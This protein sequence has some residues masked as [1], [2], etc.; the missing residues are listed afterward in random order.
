MKF[1]TFKV[2]IFLYMLTAG[3]PLQYNAI[4]ELVI[5]RD[6]P[7]S[8]YFAFLDSIIEKQNRNTD[9]ELNEHV[10]VRANSWIIDTLMQTDYYLQLKKGSFIDNQS[11]MIILRAGQK[12]LIPDSQMTANILNRFK[13]TWID[14]N[15]PE[16]KLRIYRDSLLLFT[17]PVR[18][19]ENASKYL[20]MND[21]ITDLR[22][23]HGDGSIVGYEKSPT[24]FNPQSGERFFFTKR[25]DGRI[26]LMPQI[27]WIITEINGIR[28]GQLIHPTTNPITLGKAYSNG[29]IGTGEG[30]A[31]KIYYYAPIGTK[32]RIRYD[33]NVKDSIGKQQVLKDIY[34]YT[35]F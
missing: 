4:Q 20:A 31:W 8:N 26:T 14:I 2:L 24:F 34:N 18:V 23:I 3:K 21:R 35:G 7:I 16:F 15:I 27:P 25:D 12:L 28:N 10:L 5:P 11:K 30:D 13:S 29:C 17:L 9:Y 1:S 22:T 19:G 32:I 33:L 6:V